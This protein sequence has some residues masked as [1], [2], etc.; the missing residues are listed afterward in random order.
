MLRHVDDFDLINELPKVNK[1]QNI[2]FGEGVEEREKIYERNKKKKLQKKLMF[3][4]QYS[5]K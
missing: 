4:Y 5:F 2:V 3:I 1:N